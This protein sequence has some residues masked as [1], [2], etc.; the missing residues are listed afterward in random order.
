[1]LSNTLNC[2]L[3]ALQL[4]QSF[5]DITHKI[6]INPIIAK[7]VAMHVHVVVVAVQLL[8]AVVVANSGIS[9]SSSCSSSSI[10]VY[11]DEVQ[12]FH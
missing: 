11:Q 6:N 5:N 7:V 3:H 1:M 10:V 8:A 4:R 2:L 12:W 9:K